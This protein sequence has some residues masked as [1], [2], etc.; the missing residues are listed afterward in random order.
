MMLCPKGVIKMKREREETASAL[1]TFKSNS[2][3]ITDSHTLEFRLGI[4][5]AKR[6]KVSS[7]TFPDE[8]E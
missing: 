4:F 8:R 1:F 7:I 6:S 5:N 2:S 3:R